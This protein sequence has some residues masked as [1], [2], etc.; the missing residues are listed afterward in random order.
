MHPPTKNTFAF[1]HHRRQVDNA[2]LLLRPFNNKR[3]FYIEAYVK[4]NQVFACLPAVW[5]VQVRQ[6]LPSVNIITSGRLWQPNVETNVMCVMC[7]EK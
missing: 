3:S 7:K 4:S 1:I 5:L 6:S 2:S